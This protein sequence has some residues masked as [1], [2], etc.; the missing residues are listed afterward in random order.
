MTIYNEYQQASFRGVKFL[1]L[2]S[3]TNGGRKSVTHEY[4]VNDLRYVEDMGLFK[5]VFSMQGVVSNTDYFQ[6]RDA[7]LAAL[8]EEGAGVLVH[9]TFGVLT[10]FCKTYTLDERLE[11]VGR[12]DFNITFEITDDAILPTDSFNNQSLIVKDAQQALTDAETALVDNYNNPSGIIAN[13]NDAKGKV[14]DFL[15]KVETVSNKIRQV[16]D[17]IND[18]TSALT[19]FR[20]DINSLITAPVDLAASVTNM[21]QTIQILATNPI[22]QFNLFVGLYNFGGADVE[23]EQFTVDRR[24]KQQNRDVLNDTINANALALSY[25]TALNID[26]SNS[27]EID[28]YR[29]VLEQQYFVVVGVDEEATVDFELKERIQ[30]LRSELEKFYSRLEK[31]VPRI[32]TIETNPIPIQVLTYSYYGSLDKVNDLLDLNPDVTNV[33]FID[34]DFNI[35]Q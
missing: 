8:D 17:Q 27:T 13:F 28:G 32:V 7:L 21:F 10:V 31:T 5:K 4:P 6:N 16:A 30:R 15:D 12:A 11:K 1:F 22:D 29:S 24:A 33:S 2:S 20:E 19:K 25:Q 34:G 23:F 3:V 9:P 26:Y 14:T 18:F 35:L